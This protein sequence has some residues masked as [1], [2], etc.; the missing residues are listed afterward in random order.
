MFRLSLSA[1]CVFVFCV[2]SPVAAA[3]QSAGH[4]VDPTRP[5]YLGGT[6]PT[7]VKHA[8]P[9]KVESI[10][11]GAQ[12]R[13]AVINGLVFGEG[14]R[15]AGLKVWRIHADKVEISLGGGQRRMLLLS[16]SAVQKE[17]K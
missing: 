4:I 10:L 16:S 3:E 17:F 11:F 2:C 6:T 14:D 9:H 8:A 12:R 13:V 1:T 15:R 5:A 7:P